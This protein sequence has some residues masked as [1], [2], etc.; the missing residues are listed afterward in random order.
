SL[1]VTA[2]AVG[3]E[4]YHPGLVDAARPVV[5]RAAE[6]AARDGADL[7][8]FEHRAALS[9]E[10]GATQMNVREDLPI[11]MWEID[12]A[13]PY[14]AWLM[15][16]ATLFKI[17]PPAA[18]QPFVDMAHVRRVQGIVAQRCRILSRY[19]LKGVWSA[20]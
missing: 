19:G 11:A 4:R 17:F 5:P 1:L 3:G 7:A 20:N 13:D 18:V 6:H 9:R 12:P 10:L 15:H 16:H 2:A 14:P 8:A